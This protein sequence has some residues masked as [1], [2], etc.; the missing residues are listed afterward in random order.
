MTTRLI[1]SI[2]LGD[3]CEERERAYKRYQDRVARCEYRFPVSIAGNLVIQRLQNKGNE[4]VIEC[5]LD[6]I[7]MEE[8]F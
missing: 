7:F 4:R 2:D 8:D 6:G 5:D 1:I 3:T